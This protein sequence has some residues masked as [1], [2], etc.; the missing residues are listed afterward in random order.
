MFDTGKYNGLSRAQEI[1][2]DMCLGTFGVD[3]L[4]YRWA[5][6]GILVSAAV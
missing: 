5:D 3:A 1:D 2:C 6:I 4:C